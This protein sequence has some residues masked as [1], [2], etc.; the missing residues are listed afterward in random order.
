EDHLQQL[1]VSIKALLNANS[2][3][4]GETSA[5]GSRW[6]TGRVP[7]SYSAAQLAGGAYRYAPKYR[8]RWLLPTIGGGV[9]V[10]LLFG[11]VWLYHNRI[12]KPMPSPNVPSPSEAKPEPKKAEA[13]VPELVPFISDHDRATIRNT[14]LPAD[15]H[16]ALAISLLRIGFT[17]GQAND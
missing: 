12:S 1:A 2:A 7:P 16:K 13:L 9:C 3:A 4:A 14:Y 10:G 11:G 6:Q 17:S 8:A 15:D 5:T